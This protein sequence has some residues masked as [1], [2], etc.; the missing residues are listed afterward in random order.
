MRCKALLNKV[1]N[2]LGINLGAISPLINQKT[3]IRRAKSNGKKRQSNEADM[4]IFSKG[5]TAPDRAAISTATIV[6]MTKG[7]YRNND[8][9]GARYSNTKAA[10]VQNLQFYSTTIVNR[11]KNEFIRIAVRLLVLG[12]S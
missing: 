6:V 9:T 10:N 7:F 3:S 12:G 5:T 1:L 2:Q 4:K 11:V 8:K